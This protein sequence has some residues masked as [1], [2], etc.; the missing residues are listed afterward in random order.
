VASVNLGSSTFWMAP[1]LYTV[2]PKSGPMRSMTTL[3]DANRA[4]TEDLPRGSLKIPRWRDVA[5]RLVRASE[6]GERGDIESATAELVFALTKEGWM[7]RQPPPKA[8]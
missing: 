6:T 3:L 4:L 1:L 8:R 7:N 5:I 2:T